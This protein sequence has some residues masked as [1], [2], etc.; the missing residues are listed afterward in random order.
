MN[1]RV[2]LRRLRRSF[3]P[4]AIQL[5]SSPRTPPGGRTARTARTAG[6]GRCEIL[7]TRP[8]LSRVNLISVPGS[9]FLL[10]L[11]FLPGPPTKG[12][13]V[14]WLARSTVVEDRTEEQRPSK[15]GV[16]PR[17]RCLSPGYPARRGSRW[18]LAPACF[19]LPADVVNPRPCATA[20][21]RSGRRRSAD[22]RT[23]SARV[24]RD[25]QG[26]VRDRRRRTSQIPSR[27][28]NNAPPPAVLQPPPT[29]STPRTPPPPPPV[30]LVPPPV[31]L[32]PPPV[33]VPL[34]PPPVPLVP[35]PVPLV[36][37]PVPLVPPPVPLVPPPVPLVPPPVP[38]VPPP[39]PPP[40]PPP[41]PASGTT[42]PA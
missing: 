34:V 17:W 6:G 27:G 25:L 37:P 15:S 29:G 35:P 21:R 2:A 14:P 9:P 40:A 4:P 41:V 7:F 1:P 8:N 32:V 19:S 42:T 13:E 24:E 30:P 18:P 5:T 36:P 3:S 33:P 28:S 10:F 23:S 11:L 26:T 39:V 12:N 20:T 38:L 16:G 22:P 31:P